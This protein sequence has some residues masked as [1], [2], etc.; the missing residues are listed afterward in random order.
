[1]RRNAVGV[2]EHSTAPTR[3]RSKAQRCRDAATL[4]VSSRDQQPQRGCGHRRKV[5]AFRGDR[6][7][8]KM[9]PAR[10]QE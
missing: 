7:N 5:T 6:F 3:L 1:L 9:L 4:G 10:L 8:Q 2:R